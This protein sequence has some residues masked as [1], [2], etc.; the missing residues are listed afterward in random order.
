[1]SA[2]LDH[3][4]IRQLVEKGQQTYRLRDASR[5]DLE[6]VRPNEPPRRCPVPRVIRGALVAYAAIM[7][8]GLLIL[9]LGLAAET[10][11]NLLG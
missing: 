5:M 8:S 7:G 11:K 6:E 1:M 4:K 2:N 3:E 9:V 10:W